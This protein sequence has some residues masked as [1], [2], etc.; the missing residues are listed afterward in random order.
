[1]KNNNNYFLNLCQ[2]KKETNS[3]FFTAQMDSYLERRF[4]SCAS[5][6]LVPAEV[7][8][9]DEPDNKD[10]KEACVAL[11]FDNITAGLMDVR[12]GELLHVVCE[13]I[14][15]INMKTILLKQIYT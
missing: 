11:K 8:L 1:M 4:V 12:C 2:A 15:F 14:C 7:W 9:K 10:N 13:V 3:M 5:A 6:N